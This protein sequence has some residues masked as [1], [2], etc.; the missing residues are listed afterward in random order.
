LAEFRQDNQW[1]TMAMISTISTC[2]RRLL[3]SVGYFTRIFYELPEFQRRFSEGDVPP[4]P[5]LASGSRSPQL[6]DAEEEEPMLAC[7]SQ[8]YP[9]VENYGDLKSSEW[10]EIEEGIQRLRDANKH[11]FTL[12]RGYHPNLEVVTWPNGYK[13]FLPWLASN[14]PQ[15]KNARADVSLCL[16]LFHAQSEMIAHRTRVTYKPC[17]SSLFW[18][19]TP[20]G[21]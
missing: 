1:L 20:T 10:V 15:V 19:R 18:S 7:S 12:L 17:P 13:T 9:D 8:S 16:F 4:Q 2:V 3:L 14:N 5:H 21:L 6:Q 11:D